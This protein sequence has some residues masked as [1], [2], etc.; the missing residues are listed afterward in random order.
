MQT[1]L[2]KKIVYI[3]V[4][5]LTIVAIA[6]G[7]NII[8]NPNTI[9]PVKQMPK[10]TSV[11]ITNRTS[12]QSANIDTPIEPGHP[13]LQ[14]EPQAI[15]NGFIYMLNG[16]V[17]SFSGGPNGELVLTAQGRDLPVFKLANDVKV[18]KAVSKTN[19]DSVSLSEVRKGLNITLIVIYDKTTQSFNVTH[20][21]INPTVQ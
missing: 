21:T 13:S 14:Q 11:D 18:G 15:D 9:A 4:V 3:G 10:K 20:I 6:L 16:E 1:I 7:Y 5:I 8:S 12:S 17:K 2:Q 19:S